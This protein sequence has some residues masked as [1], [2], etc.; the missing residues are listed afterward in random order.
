M[1]SSSYLLQVIMYL[2]GIKH[3]VTVAFQF[4]IFFNFMHMQRCWATSPQARQPW[5]G[6]GRPHRGGGGCHFDSRVL[7]SKTEADQLAGEAN[8]GGRRPEWVD[9]FVQADVHVYVELCGARSNY[10]LGHLVFL[11]SLSQTVR[12]HSGWHRRKTWEWEFNKFKC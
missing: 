10:Q 9:E 8:R 2:V 6:C 5:D 12:S 11:S 7:L 1:K 4:F 3:P